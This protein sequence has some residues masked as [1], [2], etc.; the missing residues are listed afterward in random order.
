MITAVSSLQPIELTR[1]RGS[2]HVENSRRSSGRCLLR[3][4]FPG[5]SAHPADRRFVRGPGHRPVHHRRPAGPAPVQLLLPAWP[6]GPG[7]SGPSDPG[8]APA[9][10]PQPRAAEPRGQ[11]LVPGQRHQHVRGL[12]A[13]AAAVAVPHR[14]VPAVPVGHDQRCSQQPAAPPPLRRAPECPLAERSRPFEPP[15]CRVRGGVRPLGLGRLPERPPQPPP[16]P[17]SHPKHQFHRA[18]QHQLRGSAPT[19][20]RFPHPQNAPRPR[21]LSAPKG[22][23][24]AQKPLRTHRPHQSLCP[25]GSPT[26]CRW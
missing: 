2:S 18:Y 10:P 12:P 7:P 1:W 17:P 5:R 9:A 13:S 3:R 6:A 21:S 8:S 11:S 16:L 4:H 20:Q 26:R 25:R 19:A 24:H 14:H 15:G 22:T 23:Q